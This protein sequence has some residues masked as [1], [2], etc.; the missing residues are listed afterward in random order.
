MP[1]EEWWRGP[2]QIDEG[3]DMSLDTLALVPGIHTSVNAARR[4]ACATG[5]GNDHR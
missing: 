3:V 2:C 1:K 5:D 4:S